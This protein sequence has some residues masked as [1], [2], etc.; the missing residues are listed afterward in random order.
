[1][2]GVQHLAMANDHNDATYN[3]NSKVYRWHDASES[4]VELQ[5]IPTNGAQAWA[6]FSMDGVQHL[7][8]ANNYNDATYNVNSKVY[9]WH[10]ASES[11]VELQSIPTKGAQAWAAFSMD[12]VQH[13]AVANYHNDATYNVNSTVYRWH[14]ASES[15]VELQSISTNGAYA[16]AAFS[17]D[18]VQHLAVANHYNS[19]TYNL[20]SKVY[21]WHDASESFV[22]LQSIPTKGAKAWA[23]FS[24]DGVQHLAVANH[25]NDA[26]YNVNSKVYRWHDASESFMELQSIPTNGAQMDHHHHHDDPHGHIYLYGAS[27]DVWFAFADV[28]AWSL[29]AF[30]GYLAVLSLLVLMAKLWT[31]A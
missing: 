5:S 4:F 8:V 19:R 28:G 20:N 12:G 25:Y 7:A 14:N 9:R 18:G 17:M 11:F 30:G 15:F 26:T 2:D 16:W 13:L 23:A 21:R 31:K 24:M 10:D 27:L 22:E 6:A 1:M 3:V 29:V